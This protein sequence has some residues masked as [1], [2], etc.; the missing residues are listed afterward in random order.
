MLIRE[1]L[2]W[3]NKQ[4]VTLDQIQSSKWRYAKAIKEEIDLMEQAYHKSD[5]EEQKRHMLRVQGYFKK[6]ARLIKEGK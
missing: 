2:T 3:I 5:V 4:D 6:A 1:L